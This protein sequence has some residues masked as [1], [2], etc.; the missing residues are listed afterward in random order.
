LTWFISLVSVSFVST[1]HQHV[2]QSRVN[3]DNNSGDEGDDDASDEDIESRL[4]AGQMYTTAD[5][6][7]AASHSQRKGFS[8][9]RSGR[10]RSVNRLTYIH[11]NADGDD[12]VNA[13][14]SDCEAAMQRRP[15][16]TQVYDEESYKKESESV[17]QPVTGGQQRGRPRDNTA[18][19]QVS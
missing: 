2:G 10:R 3:Y 9:T 18:Q 12:E 14:S 1:A 8:D 13:V 16:S 15:S 7:V 11:N 5:R 6:D 4:N 17:R 19:L